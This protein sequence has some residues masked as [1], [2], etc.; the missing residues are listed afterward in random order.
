MNSGPDFICI[1]AEKAGTTW[2]YDNI[3]HHPDVWLPPSPFKELHYFN[4][5]VPHRDLLYLGRFDHGSILRR[6]S[7]LLR[8]PRYETFRWLWRFNHRHNDSMHWYR[9]LF[10]KEGKVCGDITPLYS[11]LD[12]RGAEYA[13]KVVGDECKV[14]IVLRDPVARFWSSIKMLYRYKNI[15]ITEEDTLTMLKVMQYPYM[16]LKSDY[17]RMIDTWRSFF[18]K[19][20]FGIFFFDDLVADNSLFLKNVCRFIGLRDSDWLPP[21]LEKESNKDKSQITMPTDIKSAVSRHYLPELE[22]LSNMIGGHTINWLDN[23][24]KAADS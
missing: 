8:Y 17:S 19:D 15:D 11:T 22:R 7:P 2:L 4:D 6:Y 10:T 1:G 14:F 21:H 9:S 23:A 3:R 12:E 20:M 18:D 16:A 24:R 5:R 13:R